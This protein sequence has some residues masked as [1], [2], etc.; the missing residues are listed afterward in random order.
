MSKA[1]SGELRRQVVLRKHRGRARQ[2]E[3]GEAYIVGMTCTDPVSTSSGPEVLEARPRQ[4][5]NE[6]DEVVK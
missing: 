5:G 1:A 4:H 2:M 3:V 6:K